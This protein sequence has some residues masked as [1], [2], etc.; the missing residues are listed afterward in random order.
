MLCLYLTCALSVF[1]PDTISHH[2]AWT[3]DS[4]EYMTYD[5]Q[6]VIYYMNVA[7]AHP[8]DFAKKYVNANS[9]NSNERSLYNDLMQLE[10]LDVLEPDK[11]TYQCAYCL[12]GEQKLSGRTDHHRFSLKCRGCRISEV[13][14]YRE[15]VDALKIVLQLLVDDGWKDHAHRKLILDEDIGLV[16]VSIMPH[17]I[18]PYSCVI[19]FN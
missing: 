17:K 18:H 6:L 16:G 2:D 19:D 5:E 11:K 13:C 9:G 7:R 10:P 1:C 14:A 3:T 4:L 8:K 15:D 12:A